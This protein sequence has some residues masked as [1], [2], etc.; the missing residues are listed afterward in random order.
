MNDSYASSSM[1]RLS[2]QTVSNKE[3]LVAATLATARVSIHAAEAVHLPPTNGNTALV[4]GDL[5]MLLSE[6][7]PLL[8]NLRRV[9]RR[10]S[11]AAA[12]GCAHASMYVSV[13]VNGCP[14][15]LPASL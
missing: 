6:L 8:M 15:V 10:G 7:K 1:H 4:R 14:F 13:F 5:A 11:R 3:R 9:S 2:T 12:V